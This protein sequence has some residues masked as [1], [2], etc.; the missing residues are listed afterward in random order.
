MKIGAVILAAGYG[1]CRS[2][3]GSPFPKVAEMIGGIPMIRRVLDRVPPT[4]FATRVV[5]ANPIYEE[6]TRAAL[7]D[8]ENCTFVLQP[9][10]SGAGEAVRLALGSLKEGGVDDFLVIYG[11]MPFWRRQTVKDLANLH[12]ARSPILSMATIERKEHYPM[13]DHY[14]RVL[15]TADGRILRVVEPADATDEERG[16]TTVNPSLWIWNLPWFESHIEQV[17]FYPSKDGLGK[18]R[19]L[20]PLVGIAYEEGRKIE[21]NPIFDSQEAIGVNTLEDLEMVREFMQGKP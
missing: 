21:E 13:L 4:L 1:T 16:I 14:G 11:D 8:V 10:R 3:G 6:L 7:A 15:K 20:P 19:F 17:P 18:E 12:C 9:R 2:V 5:V